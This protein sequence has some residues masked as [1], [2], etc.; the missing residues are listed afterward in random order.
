MGRDKLS[1]D[2]AGVRLL[3]RLLTELAGVA[4]EVPVF[5]VGPD[6]TT[7]VEVS[8]VR[9]HPPGGGPVAALA[10]ALPGLDGSAV[11]AVLA[12][13]QPFAA[14]ALP[15]L[16]PTLDND[17]DGVVDCVVAV[18]G[19]GVRQPLL[20]LYRVAAL[21]SALKPG[22]AGRSMRSLLGSLRVAEVDVPAPYALDV[23]TA[24]DLACALEWFRAERG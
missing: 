21:R 3:D 18:D 8:W 11:V 23:D 1:V 2:L 13:D 5:A 4:P 16:Q 12:G 7:S 9:E 20:A 19:H 17:V 14:A 6:R 22:G 10:S 15:L 24:E